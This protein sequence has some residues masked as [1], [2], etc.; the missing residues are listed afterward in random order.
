MIFTVLVG[1]TNTRLAWFAGRRLVR[2]RV[3]STNAL[4][5]DLNRHLKQRVRVSGSALASVVPAATR[6]VTA[7]LRRTSGSLPMVVDH[8]TR[9]PLRVDYDRSQLGADRLCVAVGAHLRYP[10][11]T[12]VLDFG[13]ATTV[14]VVTVE[15][16]FL[17]G[18]ILPGISM[19]LR[20][21]TDSTARLP[22]ARLAGPR[23]V[24]AS[25]TGTGIR[26]GVVHLLSGGLN[27]VLDEIDETTGRSYRV[28]ATGGHAR[29]MRRVLRPISRVDPDLASHGLAG[30]YRVNRPAND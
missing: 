12:I 10:G 23:P 8:R 27:H 29:F 19:M 11:N 28:V 4:L 18:L 20:C 25:D 1:N 2:R 22:L 16:R 26:A 9:T 30:I 24:I 21:L 7:A 17:G 5:K 14:N 15:G 6:P 3:V 13:T